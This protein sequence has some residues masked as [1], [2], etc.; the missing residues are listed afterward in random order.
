MESGLVAAGAGAVGTGLDGAGGF[1]VRTFT[2]GGARPV[3]EV[4]EVGDVGDVGEVGAFAEH[5]QHPP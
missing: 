2:M 5:A 4:G 3:G 1:F